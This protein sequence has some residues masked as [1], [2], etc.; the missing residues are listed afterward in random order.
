MVYTRGFHPKPDM[1]FGPALSLGVLSLDEHADLRLARDLDPAALAALVEEMTRVSP[2]GLAF[3]G[4]V[5]LVREDPSITRVV[6]G[7]R[8]VL[9]FARGAIDAGPGVPAEA[10]LAARCAAAMAAET[11]PFRR[12]IEGVGKNI[13]VRRYLLSAAPAGAEAREALA[14]AG[15][16]GDLAAIE[17][18]TSITAT[19]AV[20]AAELAAVIA[21]D[22]V[23]A[24][25]HRAVRIALFGEDEAGRF[26]P[27]DLGRGRKPA[28]TAAT[29][30]ALQA[31]AE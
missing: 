14:R 24:P 3:R 1:S 6:A 29:T 17:V 30:P 8:Y 9:A 26:S 25:P 11:L 2:A 18:A 21:G 23:T 10:M 4:A 28:K 31:D 22:G 16:V 19:G 15:L 20:K 5:K 7:A 27:L 12:S 13:D